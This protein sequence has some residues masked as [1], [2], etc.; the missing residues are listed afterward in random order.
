MK[1]PGTQN[2]LGRFLFIGCMAGIHRF[3]VVFSRE[4][5]SG[6]GMSAYL[7]CTIK[8]KCIIELNN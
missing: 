4:F 8:S 5:L 7:C 1:P 2:V 3:Y 6:S